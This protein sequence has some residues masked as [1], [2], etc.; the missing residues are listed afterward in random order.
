MSNKLETYK[1]KEWTVFGRNTF[2]PPFRISDALI[3]EARI[4]HVVNGNSKLFSANKFVELKPNDTIVMKADNFV[5]NWFKN[6]DDSYNQVI[7]F[8][9]TTDYLNYI[10]NNQLPEWLSSTN[11][12][13][14][15]SAE[16]AKPSF[17]IDSTL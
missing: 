10:Y 6:E 16:K 2:K 14:T 9:L 3:N 12:P 7:I 1:I 11:A 15:N 13:L 17:I 8:S 4:V 5:N